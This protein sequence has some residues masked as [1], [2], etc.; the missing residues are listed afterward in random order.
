MPK[1]KSDAPKRE[2]TKRQ[3][4]HH[5][6]QNRIQRYTLWGGIAIIVAVIALV[7]TGTYL[8]KVKPNQQTVFKVEN[9]SYNMGYFIDAIDYYGQ[10]NFSYFQNYGISS[11]YPEFVNQYAPSFANTIQEAQILKESAAK[12]VPPVTV[13]DNE[14][15]TYIKDNKLTKNKA[16]VDA[17]YNALLDQKLTDYFDKQLPATAE[18]RAVLAMFLESQSQVDTVKARIA[19][20]ESFN[21]IA[22][23]LSLD[24]VTQSK[25]GDLGWVPQGVIPTTLN[26]TDDKVLDN[27]TFSPDTQINV[28]TQAEDKTKS[29]SMGYWVIQV[30]DTK[31]ATAADNNTQVKVNVMLLGS[32]EQALDMKTQLTN[33]ADFATLAKAN[34]QYTNAA[35]D[36]GILDFISKGKLGTA[37]DDVLFPDDTTKMLQNGQITDPIADKVQSTT[38]GFWLEQVTGIEAQRTLDGTNRSTLTNI[39]KQAWRTQTW[40]D[41]SSKVTDLLTPDKIT[42]A[43]TQAIAHYNKK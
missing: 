12:L 7:G 5:Q 19:K 17:A 20:G 36:G 27:L 35:T 31:L 1:K 22:T 40:T 2:L 33:G 18:Q 21:D 29:K 9:T 26:N 37:A 15:S 32:Q 8:D 13:T 23:A 38:G 24:T 28:L 14:T 39:N 43:T 42:Y 6:R 30:V 25:A 10:S 41:N 4:T 11:S 34:S 16:V 3:L